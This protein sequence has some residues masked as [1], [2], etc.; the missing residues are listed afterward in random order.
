MSKCR[1]KAAPLV[2]FTVRPVLELV[3]QP[4]EVIPDAAGYVYRNAL[5]LWPFYVFVVLRQTL[6]AHHR[7]WPIGVTIVV[8]NLVNVAL[9][10]V[11]IFGALGIPALAPDD[12]HNRT[13]AQN[14][15]PPHWQNPE[16]QSRNLYPGVNSS[17]GIVC[18]DKRGQG[19]WI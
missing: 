18:Q 16:I 1:V 15:H 10:Y 8:A 6:Q 13:L 4:P 3:G 9:N 14:V 5:S 2:L 7:I 12:A 11:L 17:Q 19:P